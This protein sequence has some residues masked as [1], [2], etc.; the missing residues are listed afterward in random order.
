MKSEENSINKKLSTTISI[1]N[2]KQT[3][4]ESS[5]LSKSKNI[6]L[7]DL[8]KTMGKKYHFINYRNH[9]V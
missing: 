5:T 1:Q 4:K 9:S 7:S 2:Q 6:Y 8:N 3:T